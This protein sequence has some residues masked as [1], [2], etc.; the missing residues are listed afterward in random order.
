M[1]A[2]PHRREG[3]FRLRS[4]RDKRWRQEDLPSGEKYQN[5]LKLTPMDWSKALVLPD[6]VTYVYYRDAIRAPS[7]PCSRTLS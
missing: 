5:F 3:Q 2:D 4:L 1:A 6:G 7:P